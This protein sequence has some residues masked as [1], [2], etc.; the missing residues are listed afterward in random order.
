[1]ANTVAIAS[2][3]ISIVVFMCTVYMLSVGHTLISDFVTNLFVYMILL[4]VT[5]SFYTEGVFA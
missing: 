3:N 4:Y 5:V 2:Y 1:M